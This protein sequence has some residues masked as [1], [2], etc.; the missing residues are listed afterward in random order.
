MLEAATTQW[1]QPPR[2]SAVGALLLTA[3]SEATKRVAMP[4]LKVA[5]LPALTSICSKTLAMASVNFTTTTPTRLTGTLHPVL[6][7]ET[8]LPWNCEARD[9][10]IGLVYT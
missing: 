5:S 7:R 9:K 3:G 10:I 4:A 1:S 6:G 2:H 8:N